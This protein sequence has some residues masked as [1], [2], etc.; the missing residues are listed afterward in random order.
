M[1]LLVI[2]DHFPRDRR[3]H[4]NW[5]GLN[6]TIQCH[7]WLAFAGNWFAKT[8]TKES[9]AP[10]MMW[11][12]LGRVGA[13][14]RSSW[15]QMLT[16]WQRHLRFRKHNRHRLNACCED[17]VTHKITNRKAGLP[18]DFPIVPLLTI[19]RRSLLRLTTKALRHWSSTCPPES[20]VEYPTVF[21]HQ[22]IVDLRFVGNYTC[23]KHVNQGY[24]VDL[25]TTVHRREWGLLS[26]Q[27]NFTL[28]NNCQYAGLTFCLNTQPQ[29]IWLSNW[30][31]VGNGDHLDW[32]GFV[33]ATFDDRNPFVIV[34]Y[35]TC[36]FS[37]TARPLVED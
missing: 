34:T 17:V 24:I 1:C 32:L 3:S 10:I 26:L 13:V 23:G 14:Q 9:V 15:I 5:Q 19:G 12:R 37:W 16:Y 21:R 33:A 29:P 6:P 18:F 2:G 27:N 7:G 22:L 11:V 36:W 20:F 4:C 28:L 31:L 30:M 25:K 8:C 35:H